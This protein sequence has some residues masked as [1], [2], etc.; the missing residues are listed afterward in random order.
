MPG[1]NERKVFE[2]QEK[3][4][5]WHGVTTKSPRRQEDK[6]QNNASL[7][8]NRMRSELEPAVNCFPHF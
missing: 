2:L 6:P 8:R 3:Y 4:F 1:F 5:P 7:E